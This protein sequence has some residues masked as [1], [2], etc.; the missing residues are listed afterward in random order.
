MAAEIAPLTV[1]QNAPYSIP[2]G[3]S[4]W[5]GKDRGIFWNLEDNETTLNV[6]ISDSIE[7][8][9]IADLCV[10]VEFWPDYV[11]ASVTL[12]GSNGDWD[13][14]EPFVG[15]SAL[16]C[17]PKVTTTNANGAYGVVSVQ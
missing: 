16:Y 9:V 13:R 5:I 3:S 10:V 2:R 6:S 12:T 7:K 17:Y 4:S 1:Y 14:S 15:D 8:T 11:L